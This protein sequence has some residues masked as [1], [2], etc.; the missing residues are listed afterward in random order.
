MLDDVFNIFCRY[1]R[2]TQKEL[3]QCLKD[4]LVYKYNYSIIDGKNYIYAKGDDKLGV[5]LVAHLDTVYEEKTRHLMRI[6]R[7]ENV[8]WSPDGLGADDRAGITMIMYLLEHTNFRPY[9]IFT[10]DE[11]KYVGGAFSLVDFAELS[12]GLKYLIELD[13]QGA[14][15]CV[16]YGCNNEEFIRYIE[17]F[18]FQF[19]P[20]SYTDIDILCPEWDIAGVNLSVGY[21]REHSYGEYWEIKLWKQTYEKLLQILEHTQKYITKKF[22]YVGF[23]DMDNNLLKEIMKNL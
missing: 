6:Y 1:A 10:H 23:D 16:F 4:E 19:Q 21:F 22:D 14:N 17:N 7:D 8:V 11:E 9:I 18:G 3:H 15:D 20:G 2:K 12:I 13:R 5:C